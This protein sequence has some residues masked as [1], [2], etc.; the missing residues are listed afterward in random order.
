MNVDVSDESVVKQERIQEAMAF[1]NMVAPIAPVAN[2]NMQQVV[3]RVL[4][5][6]G[7]QDVEQYFNK[8]QAQPQQGMM[9]P[10]Q[11]GGGPPQPR[12]ASPTSASRRRS[13]GQQRLRRRP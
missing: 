11:N 2:V 4:E 1:V 12:P 9:A 5:S 7:V 10:P 13:G 3:R 8:P 6:Q